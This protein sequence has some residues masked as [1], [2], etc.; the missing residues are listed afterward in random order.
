MSLDGYVSGA[1]DESEIFAAVDDFTDSERY[2]MALLE[3]VDVALLGRR[4]YE[5]FVQMWPTAE[6]EPMAELV[7]TV[8]KVVCSTT[9][10]E[11]PWGRY[12]LAQIVRDA[13]AY[14]RDVQ[15]TAGGDV[16]I[17]GS[18]NLMRSLLRDRLIDELDIF[19]APIAL[20]TGTS[21]VSPDGPYRLTQLETDVWP[22]ATH[23]R[24][25]ID[26]QDLAS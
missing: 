19:I 16:L 4:S 11:A 13:A 20:G 1:T 22:S 6:D 24:Y 21:L 25:A 23:S 10:E 17:W 3:H 14:V 18:V 7:N 2:N 12:A 9:L 5:S 8:T 26:Y 15:S